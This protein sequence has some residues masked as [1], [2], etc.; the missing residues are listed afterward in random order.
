MYDDLNRIYIALIVR[1]RIT[2]DQRIGVD[3]MYQA[4]DVRGLK[5]LLQE[6]W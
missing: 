3:L 2:Q 5:R 1:P 6:T 4:Q